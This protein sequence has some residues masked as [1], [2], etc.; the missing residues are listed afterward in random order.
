MALPRHAIIDMFGEDLS[1]RSLEE[2]FSLP[3]FAAMLID[4]Y[5]SSSFVYISKDLWKK[6]CLSSL[7]FILVPESTYVGNAI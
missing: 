2:M 7:H 6:N 1:W 4:N 5:L 3:V